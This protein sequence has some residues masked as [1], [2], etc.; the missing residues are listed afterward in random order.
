MSV[1][2]L[3][4]W[5]DPRARIANGFV[6]NDLGYATSGF[7]IAADILR[8]LATPLP[9]L[10]TKSLL[11]FG[12]GTGRVTRPLSYFFGGT[13]GYDPNAECIRKAD[14][15][16][17][18]CNVPAATKRV[19]GRSVE[20]PPRLACPNLVFVNSVQPLEEYDVV[21]CIATLYHLSPDEQTLAQDLIVDALRPGG[22]A[23]LHYRA[24][25]CRKLIARLWGD[26]PNPHPRAGGTQLALYRKDK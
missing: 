15:E 23:V 24:D 12:C 7:R 16:T 11:D 2:D 8:A 14:E 22:V 26:D 1:S 13:V 19:S 9:L 6:N 25:R 18:R 3:D 17:A 4:H 21:V 10:R 20:V 5:S